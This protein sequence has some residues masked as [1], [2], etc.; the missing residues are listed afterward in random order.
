MSC[1]ITDDQKKK[2]V[3]KLKINKKEKDICQYLIDQINEEGCLEDWHITKL[4][5]IGSVGTVFAV[6]E[7]TCASCA[8][9]C[10]AIKIQ[11]IDNPTHEKTIK[12]E[13]SFQKAAAP[14]APKIIDECYFTIGRQKCYSIVMEK[15]DGE[16]DR[17]LM[18]LKSK[19]ILED[20]AEQITSLL[21]YIRTKKLIHGDLVWFNLG[22]INDTTYLSG[23]RVI[24]LD[25]D[26]SSLKLN[27]RFAKIDVLRLIMELYSSVATPVQKKINSNNSKHLKR[28]LISYGRSKY[29]DIFNEI[30]GRG[31]LTARDI[32]ESWVDLYEN[33]CKE[34]K[35]KCLE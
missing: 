22:Y 5:G 14:F 2:I 23:I 33:Y 34:A 20:I 18:E 35:V 8:K 17:W 32:E 21:E 12:K 31:G 24:L 27:T 10:A 28:M 13:S 3:S 4:L 25:F 11:F 7:S 9:I 19:S 6:C 1:N 29:G 16:M 30:G 26:R 15:L